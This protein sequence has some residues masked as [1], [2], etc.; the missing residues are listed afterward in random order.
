MADP[1]DLCT[2]EDIKSFEQH[3]EET[4]SAS[5]ALTSALITRA[6][7]AISNWAEREF[8]PTASAARTF[9]YNGSGILNLNPYDLRMITTLSYGYEEPETLVEGK[10][11]FVRPKPAPFGTYK[12][13]QGLPA[14]TEKDEQEVTITG[15]WGMSAI[16]Q[17]VVQAT[18]LCV[19]IWKRGHVYA[20]P[21]QYN[22][23]DGPEMVGVPGAVKG[24]VS[25]YRG[26]RIG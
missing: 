8:V 25:H 13:I 24:L 2:L 5:D 21:T 17:D 10:D 15:A 19:A 14:F 1:A 16:P 12:W 26:A 3:T 18:V 6:S 7:T 4:D 22:E 9:S 11:F 23:N 20:M